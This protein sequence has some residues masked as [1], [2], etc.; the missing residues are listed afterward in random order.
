MI[1]GAMQLARC[2]ECDCVLCNSSIGVAFLHGR[3]KI[4][5]RP[6]GVTAVA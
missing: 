4:G 2:Q 5:L 3:W 1:A 6:G